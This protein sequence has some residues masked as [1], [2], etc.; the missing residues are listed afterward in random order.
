M[1]TFEERFNDGISGTDAKA[2]GETAADV[3][4]VVKEEVLL[5]SCLLQNSYSSALLYL[6][7]FRYQD[8]AWPM[9]ASKAGGDLALIQ[10][11]LPFSLKES[12]VYCLANYRPCFLAVMRKSGVLCMR[13]KTKLL[14][15][16]D[17]FRN[18]Q[19]YDEDQ[20]VVLNQ[21][22]MESML[23][24]LVPHTHSLTDQVCKPV[25][26]SSGIEYS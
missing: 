15:W 7:R 20:K 3:M 25:S 26:T 9:N 11:S 5:V 1:F 23:C 2:N 12:V 22:L 17:F 8:L 10:T 13:R 16:F 4:K 14:M 6:L 24:M 21:Y 19:K 18:Q